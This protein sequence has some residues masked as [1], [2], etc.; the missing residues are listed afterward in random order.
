M[1]S[2]KFY[3]CAEH[4]CDLEACEDVHEERYQAE[5][6][7]PAL[8]DEAIAWLYDCFG[9]EFGPRRHNRLFIVKMIN[10]E[11]EGGWDQFVRD[12]AEITDRNYL[13]KHSAPHLTLV[14]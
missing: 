1:A 5:V 10:Q 11:Y 13:P 14:V 12:G 4:K 6:A 9:P 3:Q 2:T 8:I 7:D